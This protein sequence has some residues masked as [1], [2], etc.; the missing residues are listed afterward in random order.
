MIPY[1]R[2]VAGFFGIALVAALSVMVGHDLYRSL[3]LS[4]PDALLS[5]HGLPMLAVL[6]LNSAVLCVI[7]FK[8]HAKIK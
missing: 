3:A 8:I 1:I 6:A 4:G 7:S 2:L 5:Q